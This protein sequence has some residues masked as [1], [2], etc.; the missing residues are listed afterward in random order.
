MD[1][2]SAMGELQEQLAALSRERDQLR[3]AAAEKAEL[4]K[5]IDSLSRERDEF[6]A[7]LHALT[8]ERDAAYADA[9]GLRSALDAATRRAETAEAERA[10]LHATLEAKTGNDPVGLL[11]LAVSQL[12]VQGVAWLRGKIPEGHAAL[13]WFDKTVAT[14]QQLGC[15]AVRGARAFVVWATPHVKALAERLMTEVEGRLAKK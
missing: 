5:R 11:W 4:L 13:P 1:M 10:H 2:S 9:N 14:L 15:L 7:S 3:S 8:A 6:S 12:T